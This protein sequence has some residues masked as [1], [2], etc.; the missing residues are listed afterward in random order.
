MDAKKI[1]KA[2][3]VPHGERASGLS[4]QIR[5]LNSKVLS[6]TEPTTFKSAQPE[7]GIDIQTG[8]HSS[9]RL[10]SFSSYGNYI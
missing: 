8:E 2:M 5:E 9:V 6:K 10:F 3:G 7:S 4:S 1:K